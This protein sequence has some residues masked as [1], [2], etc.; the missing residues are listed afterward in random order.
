[1][2]ADYKN[3]ILKKNFLN[4]ESSDKIFYFVREPLYSTSKHLDDYSK[5]KLYEGEVKKI[6]VKSHCYE[7]SLIVDGSFVKHLDYNDS[8]ELSIDKQKLR[9]VNYI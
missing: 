2:L 5:L 8:F 6:K 4:K 3:K 1:M 9:T 7:G